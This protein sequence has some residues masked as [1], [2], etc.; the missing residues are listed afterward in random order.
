MRYE[1]QLEYEHSDSFEGIAHLKCA[2]IGLKLH[3]LGQICTK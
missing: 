3:S 2:Y 1:K